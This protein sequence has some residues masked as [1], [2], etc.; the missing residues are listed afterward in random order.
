M[1]REDLSM[2]NDLFPRGFQGVP[3]KVFISS[4]SALWDGGSL[5]TLLAW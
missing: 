3:A 4:V 1:C 2:A 5:L